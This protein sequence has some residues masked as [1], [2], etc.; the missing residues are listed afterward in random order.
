MEI[1]G[2]LIDRL[3]LLPTPKLIG[4]SGFGGAGK[5]SVSKRLGEILE[6]PVVGVDSFQKK[7]AFNTEYSL[8]EIMDYGRL[9]REVIQP[10][11]SGE[12]TIKYGHFDASQEVISDMVEFGNK[13]VVIIEGV[14]LF[15]PELMKHFSYT[16]WVDCPMEKAIERGKKRDREE[17][18]SP[19]D[20]L[21]DGI[22]KQNDIEYLEAFSPNK[23]ADAVIKNLQD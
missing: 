8:W 11:L 10:F 21:W 17:Y 22:W 19:N 9:E 4:V 15:R 13:G 18:N 16:I 5:S 6:A 20:E 7:G 3:K 12:E 1:A 2:N 23:S 14:G